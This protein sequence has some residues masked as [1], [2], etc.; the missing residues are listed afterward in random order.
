MPTPNAGPD[1]TLLPLVAMVAPV[2]LTWAVAI[3]CLAPVLLT[4]ARVHEERTR[5]QA[6]LEINDTVPDL[7]LQVA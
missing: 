4:Y 2:F 1:G 5:R 3:A 6:A 7:N